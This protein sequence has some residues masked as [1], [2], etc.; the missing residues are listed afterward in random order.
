MTAYD[1]SEKKNKIL[2]RIGWLKDE[3]ENNTGTVVLS[4]DEVND[5]IDC[6][7]DYVESINLQLSKVQV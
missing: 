5:V 2:N 6:L 4:N 1:L 7:K 3:T